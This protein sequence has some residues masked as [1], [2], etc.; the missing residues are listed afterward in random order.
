MA[1]KR[2]LIIEDEKIIRTAFVRAF[3]EKGFEVVQAEKKEK[4]YQLGKDSALDGAVVDL[5]LPDEKLRDKLSTTAG[6]EIIRRWRREKHNMPVLV[7][8]D[9]SMDLKAPEN[10]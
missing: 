6:L 3:E 9:I 4:G 5:K 2:V 10:T 8:T 7:V 1:K